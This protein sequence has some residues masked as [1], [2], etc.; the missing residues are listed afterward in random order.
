MI[1]KLAS[2]FAGPIEIGGKEFNEYG[3]PLNQPHPILG[4]ALPFVEAAARKPLGPVQ[5]AFMQKLD[6]K[7]GND[8]RYQARRHLIMSRVQNLAAESRGEPAT[9]TLADDIAAKVLE[10]GPEAG[11]PPAAGVWTGLASALQN[12]GNAA[13]PVQNPAFG[14]IPGLGLGMTLANDFVSGNMEA[15]QADAKIAD[16]N[17]LLLDSLGK[18]PPPPRRMAFRTPDLIALVLAALAGDQASEVVKGYVQGK[19]T[20]VDQQNEYDLQAFENERQAA[21]VRAQLGYQ[22]ADRIMAR[23]RERLDYM[24]LIRKEKSATQNKY[25]GMLQTMLGDIDR[26]RPG[27]SNAFFGR[28]NVMADK[29]GMPELK[30]SPEEQEDIKDTLESME[31]KSLAQRNIPSLMATFRN[32]NNPAARFWAGT[33]LV[34]MSEKHPE[35]FDAAGIDARQM[36]EEM[37]QLTP[38]E[39]NAMA[40]AR[41]KEAAT[42]RIETLLPGQ[43]E[44]QDLRIEGAEKANALKDKQLEIA[45]IRARHLP[46]ILKKQI[47]R[48]EKSIENTSDGINARM[49]NLQRAKDRDEAMDAKDRLKIVGDAKKGRREAKDLLD[50]LNIE[51]RILE[52]RQKDL[53]AGKIRLGDDQSVGVEMQKLEIAKQDN[54]AKRTATYRKI[55]RIDSDVKEAEKAALESP[56]RASGRKPAPLPGTLRTGPPR[57]TGQTKSGASWSYTEE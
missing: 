38:S 8:P 15:R 35:L 13:P 33:I 26:L 54:T 5:K 24:D 12:L 48:L 9:M 46:E 3:V 45:T 40:G 57:K 1:K 53:R 2:G 19:Q 18:A 27:M 51:Y 14:G 31:N 34:R 56:R 22:E 28:M 17:R 30:L 20:V 49:Q 43:K 52:Q 32:P 55:Q 6:A 21:K 11:A 41:Q 37:R 23:R 42:N 36:L 16:S 44:I 10:E 50:Q 47:E 25:L 39:Q 4:A 7:H 29:A